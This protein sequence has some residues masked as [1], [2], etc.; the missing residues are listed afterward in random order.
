MPIRDS[1]EPGR[2]CWVDLATPDPAAARSFYSELFGWDA[3]V[4]SRPEAGGYGQFRHDGHSVA[5]VGPLPAEGIPPS[6]TT[7]VATEN[8]EV[9]A[10]VIAANGG[11]IMQPPMQVLDAGRMVVFSDPT[12]AVLG[13]WE[14]QNHRGAEFVTEPGGWNW[15]QLLTR[16][17]E[18]A[19]KFYKEVFDWQLKSHPDWGEYIALGES[20]GEIADVTEMGDDFPGDVPAHWQVTFM[21]PDADVF[22]ALAQG[23]GATVARP[24]RDM[25]MSGR[26]GSVT[27]PQGASFNVMSFAR[28]FGQGDASQGDESS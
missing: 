13:L 6:W 18:G 11:T 26:V 27:D 1:Y 12:G 16:D 2:P 5:G 28:S 14:P 10:D 4:D 23:L 7:Y 8:A 3:E 21:V 25:A 19:L 24:V 9:T 17:K 20:G 22:V 15:S